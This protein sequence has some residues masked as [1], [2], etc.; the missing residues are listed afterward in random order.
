M[1][2]GLALPPTSYV[3]LGKLPSL[4]ELQRPIAPMIRE[5]GLHVWVGRRI[6]EKELLQ[7]AL[8]Q[9]RELPLAM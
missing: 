7:Q 9:L 5:L 3:T 6:L 4:S 1:A 8:M 2:Q